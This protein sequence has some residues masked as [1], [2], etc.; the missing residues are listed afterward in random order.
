MIKFFMFVAVAAIIA[1]IIYFLFA[2]S[3][4]TEGS[5]EH[6]FDQ[7]EMTDQEMHGLSMHGET[8]R[9]SEFYFS[10]VCLGPKSLAIFFN[11]SEPDLYPSLS[12]VLLRVGGDEAFNSVWY[13]AGKYGISGSEREKLRE[14]GRRLRLEPGAREVEQAFM[15][16]SG[17]MPHDDPINASNGAE[18]YVRNSRNTI[19]TQDIDLI[20]RLMNGLVAGQEVAIQYG[21]DVGKIVPN[22]FFL[23]TY[24]QVKRGCAY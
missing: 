24:P 14:I 4:S 8:K 1:T 15:R 5:W 9:G 13:E 17:L 3:S 6:S 22:Q 23:N 2:F 18:I 7:N 11:M 16:L 10:F 12:D 20:I 19:E 21:G